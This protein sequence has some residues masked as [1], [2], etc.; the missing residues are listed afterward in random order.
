MCNHQNNNYSR[1]DFLTKTSLGLG[2]VALSSLMNPFQ[3]KASTLLDLNG[4]PVLGKPHFPPKVKRVIYLFQSGAP[5]QLDLFDYKPLL[6][7]LNGQELP[8]SVR[9]GQRLTG[10]TAGQTSF[11]LAGSIFKFKQ[12]GQNGAWM[13]DL[14]PYTA[15]ITNELCFIKSM[16]T[17][18]INHDPAVTFIQTGSQFSGRPSIGSWISYGLGSDNENLPNFVVLITKDKKGQPLYSRLWGNGFLPS[19]HQ[20]TQFRSGKDPVLFLQN[21]PGISPKTRKNQL[22]HLNQLQQLQYDELEDPEIKARMSQYEM[23]FRMQTSVPEIMNTKGEPDYIYDMYG[24]DS[25][26]PETY[27]ANSLLARRLAE[28]D[29][30]FIQLYHQGW[31]THGNLPSQIKRQCKET[32]QPTAALIND[33]KQRGLLEDT[34]VIWGGEFGRTNYSQGALTPTNYGRDHH[35]KCFTIF[36]AGAGVKKGMVYG[37]TDEFGYNIVENPV[38]IHDFQ[39]T[40]LHLMGVDHERLIYKHQGRRFRLTDVHG[41]VVKDILS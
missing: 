18:A 11:P 2:A 34:L 22:D 29:V 19:E 3:M 7:K 27:A 12:H 25:K 36:M 14:M 24:E 39:A 26:I 21:P 33:L 17:E 30:K 38:H 5:S 41:N 31:D 15:K 13:S 6:V 8:E 32:D 23:A 40:L 4:D 35:P 20:G 1:R 10:M 37:A 28:K 9:K 16:H